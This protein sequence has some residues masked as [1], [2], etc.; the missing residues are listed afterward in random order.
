MLTFCVMSG[1]GAIWDY[2]SG[3]IPNRLLA[4]MLAWSICCRFREASW[5]GAAELLLQGA[6]LL[7]LT[8][9][10]Y[11]IGSVG[12]GD[13]KLIAL[14]CGFLQRNCIIIFLFSMLLFAAIFS[15]IKLVRNHMTMERLKYFVS[16]VSEVRRS[17][18]WSLY[19]SDQRELGRVGICMSGPV[20]LA[21][22]LHLGGVY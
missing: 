20:F 16:Y 13:I 1:F 19:V 2:H 6:L 17:G 10:L 3:R 5:T 7:V 14:C 12:A 22:L 11:R 18:K 9:P 21:L 8:F 4:L 15:I